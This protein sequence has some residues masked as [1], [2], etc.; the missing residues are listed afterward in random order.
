M[1]VRVQLTELPST[2]GAGGKGVQIGVHVSLAL[3]PGDDDLMEP[4][5]ADPRI[6]F[7]SACFQTP[8]GPS[9]SGISPTVSSQVCLGEGN[10]LEPWRIAASTCCRRIV[11]SARSDQKVGQMDLSCC[12]TV[13][14]LDEGTALEYKN[15]QFEVQCGTSLP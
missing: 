12:Y 1:Q 2:G 5:V 13:E 14:K 15:N 9:T 3:L 10:T 6:G 4:R 11:F 8:G 7:F